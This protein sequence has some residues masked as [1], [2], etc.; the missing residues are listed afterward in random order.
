MDE[1]RQSSQQNGKMRSSRSIGGVSR[2][3]EMDRLAESIL[4]KAYGLVLPA[5]F[6]ACGQGQSRGAERL[7]VMNRTPTVQG[8]FKQ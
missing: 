2:S 1:A 6:V 3:F 7:P 8:G 4:A 5:G